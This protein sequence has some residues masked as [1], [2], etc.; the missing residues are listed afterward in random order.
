MLDIRFDI[1]LMNFFG[2]YSS[3][4]TMVLAGISMAI[5]PILLVFLQKYFVTGTVG[6]I[7]G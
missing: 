1:G 7:K 3:T 6:A 4:Y 5:I 2:Q